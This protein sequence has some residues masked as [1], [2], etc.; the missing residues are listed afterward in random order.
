[1]R[2]GEPL[3]TAPVAVCGRSR[4]LAE[5]RVGLAPYVERRLVEACPVNRVRCQVLLC[6]GWAQR[7]VVRD[8]RRTKHSRPTV[9]VS[10]TRPIRLSSVE[11]FPGTSGRTLGLLVVAAPGAFYALIGLG[12]ASS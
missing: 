1:V 9:S 2:V 12:S 10:M 3:F 8:V 4:E 7:R 5:L 6:E 11:L